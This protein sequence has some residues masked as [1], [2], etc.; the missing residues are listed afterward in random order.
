MDYTD[1]EEAQKTISL[2]DH[3]F[4]VCFEQQN[5]KSRATLVA[6]LQL[7]I[8]ILRNLPKNVNIIFL[9]MTFKQV[10][11]LI[12]DTNPVIKILAILIMGELIQRNPESLI[13]NEASNL[14]FSLLNSMVT[15]DEPVRTAAIYCLESMK[16]STCHQ[17]LTLI[18]GE[19]WHGFLF[20]L[21]IKEYLSQQQEK[22]IPLSILRYLVMVS[23]ITTTF[24][25]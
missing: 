20:P 14:V 10:Q 22:K 1:D 17:V 18:Q 7:A 3:I 6:L 12:D 8:L 15:E 19:C 13:Y 21:F 2:L 25:Q 5:A 11:S 16:T 23:N 24:T 9:R 4:G